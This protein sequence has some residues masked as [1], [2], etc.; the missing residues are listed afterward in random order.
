MAFLYA[1]S[2]GSIIVG[3]SPILAVILVFAE[4]YFF[5]NLAILVQFCLKN[6]NFCS[7]CFDFSQKI[8]ILFVSS[9]IQLYK[10]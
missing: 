6:L 4:K 10:P 2:V 8:R 5:R 3:S 1:P 7:K 9:K